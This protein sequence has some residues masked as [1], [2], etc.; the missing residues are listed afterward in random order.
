MG[1]STRTIHRHTSFICWY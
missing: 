1:Q